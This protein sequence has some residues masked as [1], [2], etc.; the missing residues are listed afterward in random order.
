LTGAKDPLRKGQRTNCVMGGNQN[1]L[2]GG[3]SGGM[4]VERLRID[5]E[6]KSKKGRNR[7]LKKKRITFLAS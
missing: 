1:I 5:R 6:I 2:L 4:R 7:R 3:E